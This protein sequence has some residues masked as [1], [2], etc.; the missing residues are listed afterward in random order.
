MTLKIMRQSHL[1]Q[2]KDQPFG[3]IEVI[4]LGA[5]AIV[6]EEHVMIVVVALAERNERYPPTITAAVSSPMGLGP[7]EMTNRIDAEGG[8]EHEKG[9]AYARQDEATESAH[10]ST[11][12]KSHH[13]RERES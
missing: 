7:P 12:E 13:K 5:I 4:P 9:T 6:P 8:I 3:G 11:I 2:R 1:R 10:P